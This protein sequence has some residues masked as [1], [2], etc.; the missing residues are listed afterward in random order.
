MAYRDCRKRI[1]R[2]EGGRKDWI[3]V[4]RFRCQKCGS[5]HV[6]LPD[7]LLPYK[8]YQTEVVSGVLDET[9]TS[10]D[11]GYENYPSFMTMLRWLQWFRQNLENMKGYLRQ[12]F[13]RIR[14][15][16]APFSIEQFR[17][18]VPNWLGAVMRIIYNSGGKVPAFR[19]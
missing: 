3:C 10:D 2:R 18:T 1:M 4:R 19:G 5:Y 17:D 8:H 14:C 11:L 12:V 7:C 13:R 6:E 15:Q 16:S 9:V